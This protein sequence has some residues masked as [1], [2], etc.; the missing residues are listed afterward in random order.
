MLYTQVSTG[1][2]ISEPSSSSANGAYCFL[3]IKMDNIMFGIQDDSVFEKY[4]ESEL[5]HPSPR[6]VLEDRII[7]TSRNLSMPKKWGSPELCDFGSAV[8]GEIEHTEDIQPDIYRAPEVILQVPWSYEVDIWNTGC[9]ASGSSS[10]PIQTSL[11]FIVRR[12]G[13]FSRVGIFLLAK[14]QNSTATEAERT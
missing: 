11:M 12:S 3:D 14:I 7:Y 5:Q 8:V 10:M 2:P 9:M 4:E 13:T 6:K 1:E